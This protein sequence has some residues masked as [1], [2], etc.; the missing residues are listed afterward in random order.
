MS[1]RES[2]SAVTRRAMLGTVGKAAL[3]A[4]ILAPTLQTVIF[5]DARAEQR[6]RRGATAGTPVNDRAGVD[7]VVVMPG[8]TYLRGWAGYGEPPH[9]GRRRRRRGQADSVDLAAATGPAPS[10]RWSKR[11]GPGRVTFAD[12]S[13]LLTTATFSAPGLYVVQLT[14]ENGETT[15]SSTLA[16]KAELSPPDHQLEVVHT[17]AYSIDNPLWNDRAKALIVRWIPHCVDMLESHDVS[18]G[19]LDNFIEAGKALRGE[20]HGPHKGYVFADA[21]VHNAVEAMS[22]AL[23]VDPR[24]DPDIIAAQ[25]A[26]RATLE[27][28]IPI[29]LGA[30]EPDG[31]MQTAFTLPRLGRGGRVDPGPF[32]HWTR[33][34]DH[35]GYTGGYFLESA[36]MHYSMTDYKDARLYD[37]ARRLADCWYDNIGPAPKKAW[38]DGHEEMAQALVRFGRF[39]NDIEGAGKGNKYIALAKFLLDSRYYAALT[40]RER[41][42]YNQSHLPVVQQYEAVGHAVRASYLYSGMADVAMETHDPDYRSAVKALWDNIV[43]R[44]YY[45]T[46]GIASGE[47]S[48]G[49]G[50]NY[51]LRNNSYCE[52]CSSCGEIFFQSKLNHIYH[53]ARFADLY[54]ETIYNAL[55]GALSMDGETYYY[56]N[57]LDARWQRVSWHSVPCCTGNI[58]RTLLAMPTWIYAKSPDGLFVNLF[59]GSTVDVGTV[60]GTRVQMVQRTNYPWDGKVAITVNPDARKRF[61]VCIRVPD[62]GVSALYASTPDANG[63]RSLAVN[64]RSVK[65]RIERGYAVLD[66]TWARGDRIT[67][68]LPMRVQR[69]RAV[70]QVEA[71]RGKVALRYGPLI[72]NIE[73]VDVGDVGKVLPPDA[74]LAT[75]WRGDLLGGVMV[76]RG[77][78]ADGSP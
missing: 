7:R 65:P 17:R 60:A 61:R 6:P 68:E 73:Q 23:M 42:E 13:A 48:E 57:P 16:V 30:Q 52:S 14:A 20:P 22:T 69:V 19:G 37:A 15:A 55:L 50:P 9:P 29:I 12:R 76:I 63:L 2:P 10:V 8:K 59:V 11:S 78:F 1:R 47:T 71:D 51:S 45:V 3:G 27:R 66:R 75:E 34:G 35:E 58:P 4:A 28:W 25:N 67:L 5:T 31:Y 26:M 21:Y 44:K 64:G 41:S 33:R 40:P 72:Y 36:I 62:R 38:Y 18:A 56:P 43:D 70:E 53:D 54:E 74:K 24:G 32:Q 77:T 39:V 46:G 49:F